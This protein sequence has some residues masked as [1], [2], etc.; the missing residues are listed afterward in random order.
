LRL[1]LHY[2]GREQK[3][4]VKKT[5][6][7]SFKTLLSPRIDLQFGERRV[8]VSQKTFLG[9]MLVLLVISTL[10]LAFKIQSVWA[11]GTISINADGSITPLTAPI[12]TVD[13]VTYTFTGNINESIAVQKNSTIIDG[14][15]YTVKGSGTGT[16]I[17]LESASNVT[18]INTS[19]SGFDSGIWLGSSSNNTLLSNSVAGNG[20]YGIY[21]YYSSNDT[22]SDNKA[23]GNGVGI[24]LYYSSNDTLSGNEATGNYKGIVLDFS[25]NNTLSD[26]EVT[27]NP[28]YGI[29]LYFSSY[30]TLLGNPV[31][32]N[33]GLGG[34]GIYLSSSSYNMLSG[35]NATADYYSIVLDSSSGNVLSQNVFDKSFGSNFVV[36]GSVLSDYVNW[37]DASNLVNGKPVYYIV[38]QDSL[39]IDSAT[40][41]SVG[42]LALVNCTNITVQNLTLT[43]DN[44]QGAL[45]AY[46]S[47][48]SVTKNSITNNEFGIYLYYS[49]H[50]T[51]SN[52]NVTETS[53]WAI[54]LDSSF[55]N[56]VCDNKVTGN[57]GGISLSDDTNNTVSDNNVTGNQGGISVGPSSN[58]T[59][60]G[61]TVAG[62]TSWGMWLMN[63]SDDTVSG[64]TFARN[65]NQGIYLYGS[66]K[67]TVSGN[68]VV[69]N[70]GD[71]IYVHYD[72]FNERVSENNVTGNSGSGIVLYSTYNNT[73]SVN[74]TVSGNEASGNAVD[75]TDGNNWTNTT[76]SG[77]EVTGNA[78]SGIA[79]IRTSGNTVSGNNAVGNRRGIFLD[80][81]SNN[82]IYHNNIINNTQQAAVSGSEPNMW[83]DSY[84]SG[85]NYW[86]N[87]TGVD[88]HSSPFQNDTGSDGIGDTPYVIDANDAD[89]Y[90][91]MAPITS[92]AA[93]AWDGTA[94]NVDILSNSTVSNLQIDIANRTVSFNVTGPESTPGF[95]RVTIPNI[96][97]QDLW[98]GNYTVLL[99]NEQWPLTNWT[100]TSNTYIYINYT[101]SEHEV[102]IVPE[103]PSSIVVWLFTL[104]LTVAVALTKSRTCR[105]NAKL[106]LIFYVAV[107]RAE[108]SKGSIG[109]E[110]WTLDKS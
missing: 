102:T 91:L 62:S 34:A 42:Y 97:V 15:G 100:D 99:N 51:V 7:G 109:R 49:C 37:V 72:C 43:T 103:F 40:H 1:S 13:N 110:S 36:Y 73:I 80:N 28:V 14:A 8:E 54:C 70:F 101:H 21:F 20:L 4:G 58:D 24:Y 25:S 26:N 10:A 33:A 104:L 23:S 41:P 59:V 55:N 92:Y 45:L 77:N 78:E 105:K 79:L 50:D 95:C 64:N 74:A 5:M 35:N 12:S 82:T 86:S 39:V 87:Y 3:L 2:G 17:D 30:N 38:N 106:T 71:G 107:Y 56:A 89:H 81:S 60:S 19:I 27:E 53:R 57:V 108:R 88:S 63:S 65:N 75:A 67:D 46:T 93:G 44:W 16:G 29:A 68:D 9:A 32:G 11:D 48:S 69:G 18:I 22:L 31:L 90:P 47:G 98:H 52:N 96:I 76:V 6:P 61:N 85:G 66:L 83:D 94:Y 84:P